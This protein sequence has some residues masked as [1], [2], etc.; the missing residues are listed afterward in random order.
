MPRY[1][2]K[3][4]QKELQKEFNSK[5]VPSI[6]Q[7]YFVLRKKTNHYYRNDGEYIRS[8]K[9]RKSDIVLNSSVKIYKSIDE[10]IESIVEMKYWTN[11][12]INT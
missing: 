5:L 8:N 2:E 9:L 7:A 11:T 4:T 10:V 12:I 6:I 3:I 1:L